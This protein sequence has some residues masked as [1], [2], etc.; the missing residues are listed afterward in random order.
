MATIKSLKPNYFRGFTT[1][2]HPLDLS[3]PVTILYG[4]NAVGK[5]S[6]LNAIEWCLFGESCKGGGTGMRER[7]DWEPQNRKAPNK[8]KVQ[9]VCQFDDG[10]VVFER[11]PSKKKGLSG[12][13]I[14]FPSG[15]RLEGDKAESW[16]K[17]NVGSFSNFMATVY[18]HQENIRHLAIAQPKD[19]REAISRLLGLSDYNDLTEL[20]RKSELTKVMNSVEDELDWWDH[21]AQEKTSALVEHSRQIGQKISVD[22]DTVFPETVK[23]AAGHVLELTK[24]FAGKRKGDWEL[25]T[26]PTSSNAFDGFVSIVIKCVRECF[27]ALPASER[28]QQ[29]NEEVTK[30]EGAISRLRQAAE[31]KSVAN[32]KIRDFEQEHGTSKDIGEV[33]D[34][35][36]AKKIGLEERLKALNQL[37]TALNSLLAYMAEHGEGLGERDC[38]ACG[39]RTNDQQAYL[40]RRVETLL[41]TEGK[42]IQDELKDTER[43]GKEAEETLREFEGKQRRLEA[44]IETMANTEKEVA[45][46]LL[47]TWKENEDPLQVLKKRLDVAKRDA[48]KVENELKKAADDLRCI[49]AECD[50]LK[51][52]AMIWDNHELSKRLSSIKDGPAYKD[53]KSLCEEAGHLKLDCQA[54]VDAIISA[55]DEESHDIVEA[56]KS[57]VRE[58]FGALADNP[59][60]D[61]LEMTMETKWGSENYSFCDSTGENVIPILSLGDLNS[62]ALSIFAGLGEVN[63]DALMFQTIVFDDPSQSMGSHHKKKLAELINTL[64]QNR[65]VIVSTMDKEFF[66]ALDSGTTAR[67]KC[68]IFEGWDPELGP[69]ISD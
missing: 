9:L 11:V 29:L 20:V 46:N 50:C 33:V 43:L 3:S 10:E 17:E 6:V 4:G 39:S 1:M 56:S 2:G 15:N 40:R 34:K 24:E 38:P 30:I 66:E 42:D 51:D 68:V 22:P 31:E 62:L 49:E 52:L 12:L 13:V 60:I 44:A 25:P 35:L 27:G 28:S 67:K 57:K 64:A 7:V 63:R 61:A 37:A 59:G 26:I 41:S 16:V 18:Q 14:K 36:T 32:N 53:L 23:E 47:I 21:L 19:Q 45:Q 69:R 8:C 58:Y 5:S 54:I 48:A 55:R 65:Q